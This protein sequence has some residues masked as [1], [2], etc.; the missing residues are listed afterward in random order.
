MSYN[1][2]VLSGR[3]AD[4][5]LKMITTEKRFSPGD[6]LP[7]EIELSQELGV[8]RTTLRE[9]VR[10][11]STCGILEIRRGKGTF[12]TDRSEL[13]ESFSMDKMSS[14]RVNM[15]DL[16][17]MRLMFEPQAAYYAAKRASNAEIQKI[18]EYGMLDEERM[19]RHEEQT[20]MEQ[21]FHNAIAKATHNDFMN[22]LMPVIS[23][24]VYK[25]VILSS[26]TPEVITETIQDHRLIM[27]YLQARNPEGAKTAMRLHIMNTIR[28]FG[29][30]MD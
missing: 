11:L 30:E 29:I 5:I 7:N 8:S 25:G 10:I 24:A 28:G 18:V 15:K 12:V 23:S 16:Y 4:D 1:D 27:K 22:R 14:I 20:E 2:N 3:V 17:E 13:D 9:A 19:L 26:T 21:A 6:K